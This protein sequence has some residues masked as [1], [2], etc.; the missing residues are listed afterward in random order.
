MV[1]GCGVPVFMVFTVKKILETHKERL[2]AA[3]DGRPAA[4][5]FGPTCWDILF[6]TVQPERYWWFAFIMLL[7]LLIN[8][9][10]LW[11]QVRPTVG[12]SSPGGGLQ[13]SHVCPVYEFP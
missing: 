7:K 13:S 4:D 6:K 9:V 2:D 8:V 10:F 1:F 11:G 5:P 3:E 12:T